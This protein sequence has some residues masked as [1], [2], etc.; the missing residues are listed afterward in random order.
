MGTFFRLKV[1]QRAEKLKL[2][3]I[4][5]FVENL[6]FKY[7]QKVFFFIN[8]NSSENAPYRYVLLGD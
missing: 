2:K 8:K 6:P 5:G 4:K 7:F 1:F 3:Y